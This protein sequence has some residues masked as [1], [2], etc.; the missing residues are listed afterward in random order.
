MTSWLRDSSSDVTSHAISVMV[1]T[2]RI[3][4]TLLVTQLKHYEWYILYY[5]AEGGG[6]R[7]RTHVR[8]LRDSHFLRDLERDNIDSDVID[9]ELDTLRTDVNPMT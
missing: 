8:W 3:A 1:L 5:S 4:D 7:Y 9:E 2:E 6:D